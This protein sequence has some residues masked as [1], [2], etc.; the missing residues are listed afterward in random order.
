MNL[1]YPI[2]GMRIPIKNVHF[3][4]LSKA[5]LYTTCFFDGKLVRKRSDSPSLEG[6][7]E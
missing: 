5:S 3:G 1:D 7:V 6:M 4:C 2:F